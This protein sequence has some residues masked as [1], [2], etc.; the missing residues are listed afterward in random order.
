MMVS[1][2][3]IWMNQICRCRVENVSFLCIYWNMLHTSWLQNSKISVVEKTKILTS[4]LSWKKRYISFNVRRN[5]WASSLTRICAIEDSFCIAIKPIS[6]DGAVVHVAR[7]HQT[8]CDIFEQQIAFS[9][10]LRLKQLE[11]QVWVWCQSFLQ[12]SIKSN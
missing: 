5:M 9:I 4:T 1:N 12:D 11:I 10:L 7:V 8:L 6:K 2:L 3:Q